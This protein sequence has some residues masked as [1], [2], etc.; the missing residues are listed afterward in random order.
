MTGEIA[1]GEKRQALEVLAETVK[2]GDVFR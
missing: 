2:A 1:G